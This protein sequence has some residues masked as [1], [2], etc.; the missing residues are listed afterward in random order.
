MP[1][2]GNEAGELGDLEDEPL[3][4]SSR[5]GEEDDV[6]HQLFDRTLDDTTNIDKQD[7][8]ALL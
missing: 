3:C 4:E 7:N 2:L 5:Q 1:P 8:L 6:L